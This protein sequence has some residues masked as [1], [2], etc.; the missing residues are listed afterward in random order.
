MNSS[1]VNPLTL[2]LHVLSLCIFPA[3]FPMSISY[4]AMLSC[5]SLKAVLPVS[6]S[7]LEQLEALILKSQIWYETELLVQWNLSVCCQATLLKLQLG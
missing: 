7:P 4:I 3:L 1:I 6:A 2:A 5:W